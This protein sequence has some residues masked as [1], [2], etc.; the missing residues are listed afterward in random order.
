MKSSLRRISIAFF[1][2]TF[3]IGF[4]LLVPNMPA[5]ADSVLPQATKS[6]P[7]PSA[8]CGACHPE[9]QQQWYESAHS[10]ARTDHVLEQ[11][12]N[13][14]AC[15]PEMLGGQSVPTGAPAATQSGALANEAN[16]CIECHTTG[17]DATGDKS[18]SY[19]VTCEACH[20][21]IAKNHPEQPM[22]IYEGTD[23]CARCHSDARFDWSEWKNSKH[24]QQ[25]MRCVECHDPH[26]TALR[27]VENATANKSALCL[28]CHK[29]TSEMSPSSTHGRAGVTCEQCHLG[30]KQATDAFHVVPNHSFAVKVETCNGCHANQIHRPQKPGE[31]VPAA[32]NVNSSPTPY[33]APTKEKSGSNSPS[34]V[35]PAALVG[36]L[37]LLTGVVFSSPLKKLLPNKR[38]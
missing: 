37:G 19:G 23:M 31:D 11:A 9:I 14:A 3:L 12:G 30:E 2:T 38:K 16:N 18:K 33:I 34:L 22:P 6:T 5:L 7:P 15:H 17:F 29:E 32:V 27:F 10:A 1:V 4:A 36:L 28:N 35:L 8:P 21:P 24:Y 26:T 13:C 20:S 25:N